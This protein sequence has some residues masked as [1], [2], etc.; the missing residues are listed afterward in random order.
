MHLTTLSNKGENI[1]TRFVNELEFKL[2]K[3]LSQNSELVIFEANKF[4]LQWYICE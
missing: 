4:I 3:D 1:L 2:I